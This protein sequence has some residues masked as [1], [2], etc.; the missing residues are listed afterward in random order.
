MGGDADGGDGGDG[1]LVVYE[2]VKLGPLGPAV[3]EVVAHS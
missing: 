2:E 1:G 3:V